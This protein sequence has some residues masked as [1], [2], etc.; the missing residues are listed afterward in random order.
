MNRT[1]RP[2]PCSLYSQY[3]L[4]ILSRQ[5]LRVAWRAA[6]GRPRVET[7]RPIDLRTRSGG[8]YMI[9]RGLRGQIRVLRLDRIRSV[10][11]MD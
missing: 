5:R 9:T 3:E 4:A 11:V 8:E 2:I 1:Y 10:D 6:G 7:L